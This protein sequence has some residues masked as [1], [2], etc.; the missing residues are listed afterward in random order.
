MVSR[1][2]HTFQCS[3]SLSREVAAA[4]TQG[5][6]CSVYRSWPT[7]ADAFRSFQLALVLGTIRLLPR[8]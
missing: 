3:H 6:S 4:Y 8:P 7:R 1:P 2:L 5:I